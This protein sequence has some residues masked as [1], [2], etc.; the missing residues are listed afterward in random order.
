[1]RSSVRTIKDLG[2][3]TNFV[4]KQITPYSP[5]ASQYSTLCGKID[6]TRRFSAAR[7]M[8]PRAD[9]TGWYISSES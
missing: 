1:M 2:T 9:A 8:L 5:L 6:N 7:P 3:V 4:F